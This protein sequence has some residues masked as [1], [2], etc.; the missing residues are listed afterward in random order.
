MNRVSCN[1]SRDECVQAVTLANKGLSHR[2]IAQRLD[3]CHITIF[4]I[5]YFRETNNIEEGRTQKTPQNNR[6]ENC[7]LLL[8]GKT[9]TNQVT[10]CQRSRQLKPT[11]T[12]AQYLVHRRV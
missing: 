11:S 1:L 5:V 8:N 12:Q 10:I 6:P 7:F 9:L 2:N 3:V 4:R